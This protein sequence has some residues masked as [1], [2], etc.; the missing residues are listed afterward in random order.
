MLFYELPGGIMPQAPQGGFILVAKLKNV[1]LWEEAAIALGEFAAEHS[2]GMVQVGSQV[3]NGRTIHTW[4]VMPLAVAQIMPCWAISDDK[5]VIASNPTMCSLAIEQIKSGKKTIRSTEGFKKVTVKLP[6]NLTGL[7]YSD[8]KV[9]F[10]QMMTGMQQFWPMATMFAAKAKLQLPFML[11]SLT[12]IAE[13]MGPS[14]QYSWYD[15]QG[16]RSHYR[17]VGIEQ[18]IGAVAGGAIGIGIMMPALN[19]TRRVSKRMQSATN[20][21]SIGKALFIYAN[22]YDDQFP[23]NL[24]ELIGKTPIDPKML[25]SKRKPKGF[26][27]PSY[28]YITGQ[29]ISMHPVNI[30]VYENPEYCTDGLNV[31]HIDGH[32]QW[33]KPDEFL[34]DLKETY[35]RLGREMPEI[36][37]KD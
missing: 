20:L 7:K 24:E 25:E 9:Q 33:M 37:F 23:P 13:K 29:N 34:K 5:V 6:D 2:N 8:S 26:D 17:G 21:S 22:D 10:N 1:K 19:Q 27:G 14:C 3:Q 28:I 12:H 15:D 31:L 36:K 11:P 35:E 32:V 30:I 4:A 18:S 16:F